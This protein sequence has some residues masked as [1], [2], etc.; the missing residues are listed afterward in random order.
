MKKLL[1][2]IGLLLMV[3]AMTITSVACGIR[4][5]TNRHNIKKISDNDPWY[6]SKAVTIDLGIN[7]GKPISNYSVKLAG[8]DEKLLIIYVDGEYLNSAEDS[9]GGNEEDAFAYI[10]ILNREINEVKTV[11]MMP[12]LNGWSYVEGVAFRDGKLTLKGNYSDPRTYKVTRIEEDVDIE[13]GDVLATREI[14]KDNPLS[15]KVSFELGDYVIGVGINTDELKRGYGRIVVDP[16]KGDPEEI[17]IKDEGLDFYNIPIVLPLSDSKVL[18]PA[19]TDAGDRFYELDL[20]SYEVKSLDT[21]D[22]EWIDLGLI[23]EIRDCRFGSEGKTYFTTPEGISVIDMANKKIENSV[24]YDW[25]GLNKKTLEFLTLEEADDDS[26]LL[27]GQ[28]NANY[29]LETNSSK[30][31]SEF[32]IVQL[33]KASKNPHAGKTI[34]TLYAGEYINESTY[35]AILKYNK[36]SKGYYIVATDEYDDADNY[37]G[38]TSVN[39]SVLSAGSGMSNKLAMDIINGEGPDIFLN[40]SE[41]GQLN[42]ERYLVDLSQYFSD[43][44]DEKYFTNVVDAAR[45]DGKLYQMPVCFSIEGILTNEKYAGSSGIGFTFDEY[46]EFVSGPLNGKDVIRVGQAAYFTNLFNGM[47]DKFIKDGKADFSC[48]E[49]RELASYVND[50]VSDKAVSEDSADTADYSTAVYSTFYGMMDYFGGIAAQNGSATILGR[51]SSDGRGPMAKAYTS[52]A[53][54]ADAVDI[55]ACVE[56]IRMLL[57]DEVQEELA[58]S[59]H[60]VL[61]R[62]AFRDYGMLAVECFNGPSGDWMFSNSSNGNP[63]NRMRFSEN[64]IAK[65]EKI[66]QS[67]SRVSSVDPAIDNILAE[68]MPAY[69]KGQKD[70]DSV[71]VIVQDRAQKV[72]DERR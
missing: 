21:K 72:L 48:S 71:I 69:F 6:D 25:C 18:L 36:N 5:R 64:D 33:T 30:Q 26:F 13:S 34:L 56:F 52:A 70:L 61:N 44:S 40:T 58:L 11:D 7:T 57:S 10:K 35:D 29:M 37:G 49:F 19:I 27:C 15:A 38:D 63:D 8:C 45:S 50:N 16:S 17:E 42:N 59:E 31:A 47:N 32:H 51:P 4:G 55:N 9:K 1:P 66:I 3:V 62:S 2:N 41:I 43:L 53:V 20:K 67:C 28:K 46:K 14:D 60:F 54:S 12:A 22:Y 23:G 68:E 65:L 24:D 39:T